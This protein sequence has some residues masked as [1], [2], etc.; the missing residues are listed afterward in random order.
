MTY[1]R[2]NKKIRSVDQ[3][4]FCDIRLFPSVVWAADMHCMTTGHFGTAIGSCN[5]MYELAVGNYNE[6]INTTINR[7]ITGWAHLFYNSFFYVQK[8]SGTKNTIWFFPVTL[9][10][11]IF[12]IKTK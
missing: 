6:T 3:Q 8:T 5:N 2:T 7:F 10:G 11:S 4:V 12:Q 9:H 1:C